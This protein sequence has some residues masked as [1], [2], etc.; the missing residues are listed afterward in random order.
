M[1]KSVKH[2]IKSLLT[3]EFL[4]ELTYSFMYVA[5][6]D[7]RTCDL[8]LQYDKHVMTGEDAERTF[9][10]LTKEPGDSLWFPNNHPW[11]RCMLILLEVGI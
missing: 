7:D 9:P 11:C 8:C 1:K 4:R 5:V 6:V 3:L 10:Y 2:L